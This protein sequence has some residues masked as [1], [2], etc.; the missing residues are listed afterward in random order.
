M[1]E[2]AAA[3]SR[4]A[5]DAWQTAVRLLALRSRSTEEVRRLLARRGFGPGETA[6]AIQRLTVARY[7]DDGAFARAWL[8]ARVRQRLGPAR[9]A[10]ELRGKGVAED[11]IAAALADVVEGSDP[12]EAAAEAAR[13]K[14]ASLAGLPRPVA[15]RRLAGFLERKGFSA[16]II[17]ALCR[18]HCG[19]E[20]VE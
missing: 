2:R 9:L 20:D 1:R 10:R 8:A 15:R 4:P 13:R 17:V 19:G 3:D 16:D 6:A 5:P 14:A 18:H 12:L 7:L 11:V